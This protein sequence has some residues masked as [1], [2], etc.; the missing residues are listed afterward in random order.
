MPE[1]LRAHAKHDPFKIDMDESW[2]ISCMDAILHTALQLN[3]EE[4]MFHPT[5]YSNPSSAASVS[6]G[7]GDIKMGAPQTRIEKK[8][9]E[10]SAS[11]DLERFSHLFS[12]LRLQTNW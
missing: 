4:I 6:Y 9:G 12:S 11:L 7:G 3:P 8:G 1:Y 2:R 5:S 10:G